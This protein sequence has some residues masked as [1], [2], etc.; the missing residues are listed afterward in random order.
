MDYRIAGFSRIVQQILSIFQSGLL[1]DENV[2][3]IVKT[4]NGIYGLQ[5]T[6]IIYLKK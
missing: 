3:L 5:T 2:V 1:Q 6:M 4:L